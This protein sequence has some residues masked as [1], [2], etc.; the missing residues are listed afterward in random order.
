[1]PYSTLPHRNDHSES[2]PSITTIM[3]NCITSQVK[4]NKNQ[5]PTASLR[6]ENELNDNNSLAPLK[7]LFKIVLTL[8]KHVINSY[9]DFVYLILYLIFIHYLLLQVDMN[10]CSVCP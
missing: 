1:M 5:I 6:S 10:C 7:V 9:L 8:N 3:T 2:F 4:K